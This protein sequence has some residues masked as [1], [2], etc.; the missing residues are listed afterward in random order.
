M[1][2]NKLLRHAQ[3]QHSDLSNNDGNIILCKANIFPETVLDTVHVNQSESAD[4][5]VTTTSRE[6]EECVW[7][8][9]VKEKESEVENKV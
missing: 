9:E 6:L 5:I 8:Y 2:L 1:L 3:T 7:F 4:V